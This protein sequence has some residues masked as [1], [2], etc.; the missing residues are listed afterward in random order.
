MVTHSFYVHRIPHK[1]TAQVSRQTKQI[2][3]TKEEDALLKTKV[4]ITKHNPF[5]SNLCTVWNM[6]G[7]EEKRGGMCRGDHTMREEKKQ[8]SMR[9]AEE[10]KREDCV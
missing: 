8:T 6:L 5:Q 10:D 4:R 1:S 3:N 7:P 2:S 9:M